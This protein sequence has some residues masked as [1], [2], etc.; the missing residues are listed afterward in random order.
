MPRP[1][2]KQFAGAVYHVTCR[3]NGR[4]RIVLGEEDAQRFRAQLGDALAQAGVVL[5]AWALMPNHYHLLLETPRGDLA[6]FMQRLNTAYAMYF[7]YKRTRPGHC[8]QGRY[9]AKLVKG[10][11][12]LLRLTRYIHLNPVKTKA[13]QEKNAEEKWTE[14]NA[15]RWSSLPGYLDRTRA[16]ADVDY[17]WLDLMHRSGREAC[18]RAYGAYVRASLAK[19]DPVLR[20]AY[21]RSAYAIGDERHVR[22]VEHEMSTLRRKSGS[23]NDLKVACAD[24]ITAE[25]ALRRAAAIC[26]ISESALPRHSRKAGLAKALAIELACRQPRLSQRE[27]ALALGLSE[28]AV[29]KQRRR[30]AARIHADPEIGAKLDMLHRNMLSS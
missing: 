6:G 4:E 1:W 3:G 30:L 22:D 15:Y 20:E 29:G 9:G 7:R 13:A 14:L 5:Y 10:D 24:R 12:Y 26:G 23:P 8:F 17:R 28:H 18:R 21:G 11:D 16:E 2:R 27:V 19:P 25:D